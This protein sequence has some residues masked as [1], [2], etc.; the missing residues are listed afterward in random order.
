MKIIPPHP[1]VAPPGRISP[2]PL[3]PGGWPLQNWKKITFPLMHY[4]ALSPR[5]PLACPPQRDREVGRGCRWY[6][7]SRIRHGYHSGGHL[8]VG[9][10]PLSLHLPLVG[11]Q[12]WGPPFPTILLL[13]QAYLGPF[14]HRSS[15]P[16]SPPPKPIG[17][18]SLEQGVFPWQPVITDRF[19]PGYRPGSLLTSV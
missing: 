4:P 18:G 10:H 17:A 9:G 3:F 14:P 12:P 5:P 1:T 6:R 13:R 11:K 2:L 16:G 15:P 7:E 8:E 19:L